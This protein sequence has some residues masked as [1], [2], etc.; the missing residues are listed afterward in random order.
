MHAPHPGTHAHKFTLIS[1][2]CN[3][4]FLRKEYFVFSKWNIHSFLALAVVILKPIGQLAGSQSK[5]NFIFPFSS[6]TSSFLYNAARIKHLEVFSES[7]EFT[8]PTR[9]RSRSSKLVYNAAVRNESQQESLG[10]KVFALP[11]L[12]RARD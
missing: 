9:R 4:C 1:L 2:P 10:K 8:A 5:R 6:F 7:L 3:T 11:L 12:S